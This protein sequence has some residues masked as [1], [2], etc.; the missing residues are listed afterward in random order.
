MT[1]GFAFLGRGPSMWHCKAFASAFK[2]GQSK[3]EGI[4]QF[5]QHFKS[6]GLFSIVKG[7]IE[8]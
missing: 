4:S 1:R 3:E 7:C 5:S 2:G 8:V 6:E